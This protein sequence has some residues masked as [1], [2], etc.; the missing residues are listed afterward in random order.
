[1]FFFY[2][3]YL[4]QMSSY[5][6]V[7]GIKTNFTLMWILQWKNIISCKWLHF[8]APGALLLVVSHLYR[9]EMAAGSL[10]MLETSCVWNEK[11]R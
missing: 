11:T 5:W 4:V 10:A 9:V 1:M 7:R 6:N 2:L 3:S 8:T